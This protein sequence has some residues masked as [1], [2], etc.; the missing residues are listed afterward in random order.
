MDEDEE[1]DKKE[2]IRET[3]KGGETTAG[4]KGRW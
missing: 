4:Q 2:N 1:K 3:A